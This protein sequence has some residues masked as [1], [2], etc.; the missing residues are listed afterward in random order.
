MRLPEQTGREES[1]DAL[2]RLDPPMIVLMNNC[3]QKPGAVPS[4]VNFRTFGGAWDHD[5]SDD[6]Q[7]QGLAGS[8]HLLDP[9]TGHCAAIQRHLKYVTCCGDGRIDDAFEQ[10]DPHGG[11]CNWMHP[12]KNFVLPGVCDDQCQCQLT[13]V[14]GNGVVE[15]G[16]MCDPPGRISAFC[17]NE[18]RCTA[19]CQEKLSGPGCPGDPTPTA[20]PTVF[21]TAIAAEYF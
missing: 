21:A 5:F 17:L 7:A 8:T 15:E 6:S 14:C 9:D 20:V 10:C 13:G 16:E 4:T 12:S 18:L 19:T 2:S 3:P 11:E 1:G